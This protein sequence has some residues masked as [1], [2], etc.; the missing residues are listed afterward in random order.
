MKRSTVLT[1]AALILHGKE[2][3]AKSLAAPES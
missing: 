3:V 2:P 1:L